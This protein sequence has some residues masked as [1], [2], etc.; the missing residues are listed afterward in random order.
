[1]DCR[2]FRIKHV[3]YV[4]DLLPTVEMD[5]M[6]RHLTVCSG[7]SRQDTRVR[8]SLMIVRSLP[9]IEASPD[10]MT[11]LNDRIAALGP[12]SRTDVI[13]QQ[14]PSYPAVAAATAL[15]AGMVAVAYMAIQTSRYFA[16]TDS[17]HVAP[18]YAAI[19]DNPVPGTASMANAAMASVPTGIPVWPA[20]L[21]VGQSPMHF[22]N[23]EARDTEFGR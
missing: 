4:D 6:R 22:A 18:A 15:A 10:F 17:V 13:Y 9:P 12:I 21:M 5:A 16:P 11:R 3:A 19:Q 7:C 20:V 2:E 14:R 8:R 1:M 23:M